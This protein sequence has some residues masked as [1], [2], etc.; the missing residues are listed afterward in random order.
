MPSVV[1]PLALLPQMDSR[2]RGNDGVSVQVRS[3]CGGNDGV[4]AQD[5]SCCE[6]H[7]RI[8]A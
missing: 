4:G 5:R 8:G 6:G 3:C 7:D 1:E 2:F